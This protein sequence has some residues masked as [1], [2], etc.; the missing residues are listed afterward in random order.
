[1][2]IALFS[3]CLGANATLSAMAQ[4]PAEFDGIR[5]LLAPMPVTTEIV[6][7]R[8]LALAG[9]PED[10]ITD[11]IARLDQELRIRTS[12]GFSARDTREWAKSAV[13]PTFLYQ[14][15][16]DILTIPED[17]QTMYEV[18]SPVMQHRCV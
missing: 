10:Q 8:Q 11:A 14:V 9:V 12:I 15:R 17:M 6:V 5:S 18:M 16:D 13:V 4:Y 1:M 2:Q 3:R 7:G